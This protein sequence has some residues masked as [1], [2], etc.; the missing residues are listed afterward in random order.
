MTEKEFNDYFS[1]QLTIARTK[2]NLTQ[3]DVA[4]KIN[5]STNSTIGRYEN[6]DRQPSLYN[7]YQ[8]LTLYKT[9]ANFYFPECNTKTV[10]TIPIFLVIQDPNDIEKVKKAVS[11]LEVSDNCN[12]CFAFV[13]GDN[14]INPD[15]SKNDI[16]IFEKTSSI[17]E[18]GTY[19]LKDNNQTI[20]RNVAIQN[21][22]YILYSYQDK[23]KPTVK[24]KEEIVVLGKAKELRRQFN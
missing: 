6:G 19:L 16:V 9:D 20:I 13:I 11:T 3:N 7:F 15:F 10:N 2:T 8:M 21:E 4:S 24:Q 18:E 22:N 12:D 17:T 5:V 14:I 1:K 23:I